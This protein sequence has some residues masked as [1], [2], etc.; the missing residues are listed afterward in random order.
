[1]TLKVVGFIVDNGGRRAG[2]DRRRFFYSTHIPERR[3]GGDRRQNGDRRS[4]LDR[5]SGN[6]RREERELDDIICLGLNVDL[7]EHLDRR[8]GLERRAAFA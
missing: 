8:S 4:G 6:D 2:L 1:M 7:F 3:K 5:R